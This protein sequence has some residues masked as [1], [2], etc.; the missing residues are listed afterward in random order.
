M[1]TPT[2]PC[3]KQG[4]A[5]PKG[6]HSLVYFH[7]IKQPTPTGTIPTLSPTNTIPFDFWRGKFSQSLQF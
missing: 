1:Y 5:L 4:F 3:A 7:E 2:T 6:E